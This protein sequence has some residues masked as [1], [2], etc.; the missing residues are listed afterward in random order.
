MY[1]WVI[2]G[3]G[4]HGVTIA[5]FLFQLAGVD[6]SKLLIVDPNKE[7][8]LN[9]TQRALG[10]GMKALRSSL[11][12][13]IDADPFSLKKFANTKN[14]RAYGKL[15]GRYGHPDLE[16]F[17]AHCRRVIEENELKSC[18]MIDHVVSI[19]QGVGEYSKEVILKKRSVYTKN[20]VLALGN[21]EPMSPKWARELD[22][23]GKIVFHA[24]DSN[25]AEVKFEGA[26]IAIIGG[27]LTAAQVALKS[28]KEKAARVKIFSRHLLKKSQFDS[29][30]GW[31]GPKYR[32][33]FEKLKCPIIK[34]KR[35]TKARHRGS[36]TPEVYRALNKSI[37]N[38]HIEFS[39]HFNKSD[40]EIPTQDNKCPYCLDEFDII[41]FATGFES[42]VPSDKLV[43]QISK[44]FKLELSPCGTPMLK[45]SVKWG[46]GV[47]T[48]GALAEMRI[49][50][51]SR[52]I[53]GARSV[54]TE[55]VNEC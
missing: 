14:G 17:D 7:L 29:D 47:Y 45:D 48:S 10:V 34:R 53:P 23:S 51:I 43:N 13:H 8:L 15:R 26:N 37:R 2:V 46:E 44:E 24:F 40:T 35:I 12:H 31:M 5:T 16:L 27:G 22:S 3:G 9:W 30:P 20:V 38:K 19:K 50:P 18:H 32:S 6:N 11:V 21:P 33:S 28:V 1:D 54:A 42:S 41:I 36:I 52:N 25:W 39:E 55:I 49:G 4:I